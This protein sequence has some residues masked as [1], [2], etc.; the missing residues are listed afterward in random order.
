MIHRWFGAPDASYATTTL[1]AAS[2]LAASVAAAAEPLT[3]TPDP[4]ASPAPAAPAPTAASDR[5]EGDGVAGWYPT[6]AIQ[7]LDERFKLRIGLQGI[8]LVEPCWLDG[9]SQDRR[10]LIVLRPILAGNLFEKWI[11]FWTSIELA[12]NPPFLLDSWI[13]LQPIPELGVRAGQQFTPFSRHE[14]FAPHEILFPDRAPVAQFFWSGRD[15]GVTLLGT[16]AEG[17]VDYWLGFYSGTPVRQYTAI[18]GN[19]VLEARATFNPMGPVASNEA[20]YITSEGPVPFRLSFTVQG[21]YGDVEGGLE[22]FNPASFQ[23]DVAPSG[24]REQQTAVGADVWVQGP[25]FAA[26]A[27]AYLKR[28]DPSGDAASFTSFGVWGQVGVMLI[29]R[30]VDV[31]VRANLLQANVDLADNLFYSLEG[32]LGYYPYR[33]QNLLAKLRYG[34]G[35]QQDPGVDGAVSYAAPGTQHQATLE[36]GLA[37]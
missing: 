28:T 36:L 21:Y 4:S 32:T 14:S 30:L 27:E 1:L 8:Y 16:L 17:G 9:E 19:Y 34:Y 26:L 11:R 31:G 37:L 5:R 6:F 25:G 12:G 10:T 33:T 15:K 13:Q 18:D 35:K 20:P 29:D 7:S 24:E 22:T 2:L 3:E 23:Y